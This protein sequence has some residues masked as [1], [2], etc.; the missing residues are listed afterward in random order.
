MQLRQA[1]DAFRTQT[2]PMTTEA[3]AETFADHELEHA[4]GTTGV[5]EIFANC[6]SETIHNH[7]DAT[8]AFFAALPADTVGRIGYSD[9]DPIPHGMNGPEPVSF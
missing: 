9:R 3:L 1:T 6:Q 2:Y 7:H 4:G 5:G 8:M